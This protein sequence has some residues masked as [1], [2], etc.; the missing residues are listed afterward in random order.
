MKFAIQIVGSWLQGQ[1]N[2][3]IIYEHVSM[4]DI[5]TY[6]IFT[7]P[8]YAPFVFPSMAREAAPP[9]LVLPCVATPYC[10]MLTVENSIL[11]FVRKI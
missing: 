2:L 8:Q 10:A 9:Q 3:H 6:L 4:I 5:F 11:D 7:H 1:T